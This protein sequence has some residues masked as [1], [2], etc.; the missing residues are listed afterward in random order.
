MPTPKRG[1]IDSFNYALE[2]FIYVLKTQFNMRVH[3]LIGVAVLLI[4]IYFN[5]SKIELIVLTISISL[6]LLCEMFNTAIEFAT[7]LVNQSFHPMI[8]MIKDICAGAV[9]LSA[10]NALIVGYLIFLNRLNLPAE[11]GI[12]RIR[13][14]SWHIT[15]IAL[16]LVSALVVFG[17]VI[18][19]RGTPL[20]GGMPS[21]HAAVAFSIWVITVFSKVDSLL[22][23]LIFIMAFIIA[24]SRVKTAI[25]TTWE[26]VVGAI[27]GILTT[28]MV[29]QILR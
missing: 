25:H 20:R 17:K 12:N 6:V 4:G 5:I 16:I 10:V 14:S 11:V 7:D 13:Q 2:G 22:A 3:F 21:G 15:F 1:I 24:R 26:V 18:F 8:R 28:T 19:Q 29:F 27:L 9:L 23:F